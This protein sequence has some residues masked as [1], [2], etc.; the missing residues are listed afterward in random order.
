MHLEV[1]MYKAV[2]IE[3]KGK[4]DYLFVEAVGKR[5]E[6]GQNAAKSFATGIKTPLNQKRVL[7]VLMN[8]G[9][10]IVHH[11]RV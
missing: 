10:A 5:H 6:L 3:R 7:Q 4:I 2:T 1:A 11:P 9:A 8:E